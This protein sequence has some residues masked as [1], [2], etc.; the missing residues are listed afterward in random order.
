MTLP[1]YERIEGP[2]GRGLVLDVAREW[3]QELLDR[4]E[5]AY[6][7]AG[8]HPTWKSL[9]G[10]GAVGNGRAEVHTV[11]APVPGPDARARWAVRH[12]R[13]GG[14]MEALLGDVY[15]RLGPTR[16]EIEARASTRARAHGL[17]TPAVIAGVW[18][19][20]GP[21]YR[22]DLVTELVP[23]ASSLS[24]VL[25][26]EPDAGVGIGG[27][28]CSG[29]LVRH[30]ARHGLSHPDLNA[31][32]VLLSFEDSAPRAQVVDLDR[33]RFVGRSEAALGAS[34]MRRLERSLRK[35]GSRHGR[36]LSEAEW[37]AL[38]SGFRG[39]A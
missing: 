10:R 26:R 4:G 2:L 21:V 9:R 39:D 6:A 38:R 33:A 12:Y 32:N 24:D 17:D 31:S 14:A 20:Q 35:L 22:A 37:G 23:S 15:L 16:P 29:R 19:P 36:P 30:L 3:L 1:G 5:T 13:R 18:Y 27:L 11:A 25:F 28:A 7:W 8:A 34:M